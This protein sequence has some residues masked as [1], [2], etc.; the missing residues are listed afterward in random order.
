MQ[1]LTPGLIMHQKKAAGGI[2]W[3]H[4][5]HFDPLHIPLAQAGMGLRGWLS[6]SVESSLFRS[7]P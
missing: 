3:G 6:S 1:N 2:G 5:G 4:G 7:M